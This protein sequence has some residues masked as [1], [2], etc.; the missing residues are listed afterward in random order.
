[1]IV[2][3]GPPD[4]GLVRRSAFGALTAL[5]LACSDSDNLSPPP[6]GTPPPDGVPLTGELDRG[7]LTMTSVI[8]ANL[9]LNVAKVPLFRGTYNGTRV[10]F[11]RMDVSDSA[12]AVELGLNFAPRLANAQNGCPACVQTVQSS[13]PVVG[14]ADV[15]FAGT[16]DFSPD[17]VIVPSETGFP[18]I[19]AQPGSVAGPGYSDLVRVG[20]DPVVFNAPIVAVGSGPFD[21]SGAHTNTLDRVMAIDTVAMT[22][23]MQFIRAF[24]F[25]TDIFYFTFSSSGGLSSTFERATFLPVLGSLPFANDDQNLAGARAS[26][27]TFTNGMRGE[28]SPPG[29]GLT[30]VLLDN[31][32]GGLS[33]A[34]PALLNSLAIGGDAH[35]VLGAFPL[36]LSDPAERRLYSPMWDLNIAVWSDEAVANGQNFAQ[37]DANEIRQLAV[38]GLV[39]N[40]GGGFLSSANFV[41]NCPAF[42]FAFDPPTE[43]Q[44]DRPREFDRRP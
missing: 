29:Q 21:V 18:P 15:A 30:H 27:F 7:N 10:W 14:G 24:A 16:V 28:V 38:E 36:T 37:R 8:S 11:V 44:A 5:L 39:T 22:V 34:D 23:D 9:D 42:G 20:T 12:L 41:V 17:R 3:D 32:P 40:P 6:G 31:P 1:M 35:N 13:D 2:S 19:T 25:G 4:S 43:A 26:I 33:L